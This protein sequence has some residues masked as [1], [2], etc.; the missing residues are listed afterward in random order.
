MTGP[1]ASPFSSPLLAVMS[2]QLGLFTADQAYAV[3]YSV[4]EVQR[5]RAA[6][7]VRS[8]RRGVYARSTSYDALDRLARHKVDTQAALLRLREPS[9]LSHESA[10]VWTGL[11]LLLP[12]LRTVHVTRPELRVSRREAGIHHHPGSLPVAHAAVV[13]GVAV[14]APARTAVDIARCAD[15]ARGLAA[16]DSC[17]RAGTNRSD[18]LAVMEFC[19]SWPGALAAGRA[20]S[21]ADGRAAN[22]GESWSRAVLIEAGIDPTGLQ[23]E[24]RDA[25]GL[26]GYADFVWED[27]MTLGEFDGRLKYAV[28]PGA[29]PEEAARVVWAEKRREDRF[30]GEGYQVVRWGWEDLFR[31]AQLV[32]RILGAFARADGRRR[33]AT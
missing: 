16:A 31:P 10:A 32:A 18:L 11:P 30:R 17:L 26:V 1:E 19:A 4:G 3:G 13:D 5:L 27:R 25:A 28:P 20:V 9:T 29:G 7:V 8:V 2:R 33:T 24:V 21:R 22:P 23:F 6:G 14:T 15:F 12:D